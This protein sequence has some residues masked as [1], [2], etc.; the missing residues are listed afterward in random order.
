VDCRAGPDVLEKRKSV[1]SAGNPNLDR[2]PARSI[3]A[4]LMV[5]AFIQARIMTAI[6]VI[7]ISSTC[8]GTP[9]GTSEDVLLSSALNGLVRLRLRTTTW[10][11]AMSR[12]R[13]V[14]C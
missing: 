1:A 13:A 12:E 4:M 3:I 6:W 8:S 7:I 11:Q 2:R 14:V 5:K 9:R 10:H